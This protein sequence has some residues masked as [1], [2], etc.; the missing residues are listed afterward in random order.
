MSA[1]ARA[2]DGKRAGW[3]AYGLV[4]LLI[5]FGIAH[6]MPPVWRLITNAQPPML[7][8]CPPFN[9]AGTD[10]TCTVPVLNSRGVPSILPGS[11]MD[12]AGLK[13]GDRIRFDRPYDN[14]RQAAIGETIGLTVWHD[15]TPRH[16]VVTAVAGPLLAKEY[17]GAFS[18]Y[19]GLGLLCL[20][21]GAFIILRSQRRL[22]P[23][24]AGAAFVCFSTNGFCDL[25]QSRAWE[26]PWW[27]AIDM[28]VYAAPAYV[29]LAFA[30]VFREG[31]IESAGRSGRVVLAATCA[32]GLLTMALFLAYLFT[33][34][35]FPVVGNVFG[36]VIAV[37][38]IAFGLAIA[39]MV[40]GWRKAAQ[41]DRQRY[42][43]MLT[44]ICLTLMARLVSAIINLTSNN[45]TFGN[46]LAIAEAV[47]HIIGPLLFAYA[48]LRH[49]VLD[50]GFA[51]NRA[52]VYGLVSFVL[53]LGFGLIEWGA[54]KVIPESLLAGKIWLD[55]V[56]A[57]G[58]F[59]TFHR[60][61][62]LAEKVVE[63]LFFRQW[64]D[65][66]KDL[67]RFVSEASFVTKPKALTQAFVAEL[68]RFC[69]GAEVALYEPGDSDFRRGDGA[70]TLPAQVDGDAAGVVRMRATRGAVEADD[71]LMLPMMQRSELNGFVVLGLKPSGDAYRP[72][73]RDLL[74]W[75]AHQVGLDLHALRVEQLEARVGQLEIRNDE[76]QKLVKA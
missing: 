30:V 44:A 51:V 7:G 45:F 17:V 1:E 20:M 27:Q 43:L 71:R 6:D 53:L 22:P 72:D 41:A 58:I 61:R 56:I 66:E 34:R 18:I 10:G 60:V 32:A 76:L 11:P 23:L 48:V 37:E 9:C 67:R 5:V 63:D 50:V 8:Y 35:A 13:V 57:L 64:R 28:T 52:L 2:E 12:K 65:N 39:Y 25:W 75:A 26:W 47:F 3:I 46:P 21:V 19:Y 42:A 54:E 15:G 70:K 4:L 14:L 49:R 16:V 33:A 68:S 24:L 55:A 73:E 36:I 62:D 69:G 38:Y 31:V 59:L 40:A 29:F 74:S